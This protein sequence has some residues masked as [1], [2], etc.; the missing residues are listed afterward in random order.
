MFSLM[1]IMASCI[2]KC[3]RM[4]RILIVWDINSRRRCNKKCLSNLTAVESLTF[5][6][7]KTSTD[8]WGKMTNTLTSQH[9]YL[10]SYLDSARDK[11][12]FSNWQLPNE[13][14]NRDD[15]RFKNVIGKNRGFFIASLP[16][17]AWN[18]K[19]VIFIGLI[20]AMLETNPHFHVSVN[21]PANL[22]IYRFPSQISKS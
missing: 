8:Q 18:T 11:I 6:N 21:T 4:A 16:V 17:V 1:T 3:V 14:N 12:Q 13:R 20:M 9:E 22:H 7:R 5:N 2:Y 19:R 10:M 15:L